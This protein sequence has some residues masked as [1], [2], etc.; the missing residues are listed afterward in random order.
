[1]VAIVLVNYN[2]AD[3]T[4]DCV[5][6]LKNLKFTDYRIIVVDNK[7][8][9]QSVKKLSMLSS[10]GSI[11][12][13]KAE[14]NNGFSAG[15]NIGIHYALDTLRADYIWLLNNDTVVQ[16]DSLTGLLEGFHHNDHVGVTTAKTYYYKNKSLIW[17]AGGNIN[18]ITSRTEHWDYG[19]FEHQNNKKAKPISVTFAS[20]CCMLIKKDVFSK[21]GDLDESYFLYEEDTDYC[22][23][24][25]SGGYAIVYCPDA[26]IYHKVNASTGKSSG[27]VQY[28]SIRNKYWLIHKNYHGIN[29]FIAMLYSSLQIWFRCMKHELDWK[30][31]TKA[32]KAYLRGETGKS[33]F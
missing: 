26:V 33:E 20:G 3:D 2:G 28:Y 17:Y 24:V 4:I 32:L 15:N 23:R 5:R 29:K 27:T 18:K 14:E 12:L 11:V 19:K 7:S 9:D 30:Y 8:T 6:S 21:I 10:D 1:M 31:Y 25:T 22:L 16:E 13:L